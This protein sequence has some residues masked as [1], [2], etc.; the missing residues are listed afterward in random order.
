[1]SPADAPIAP[2]PQPPRDIWVDLA[3]GASRG[4]ALACLPLLLT[5]LPGRLPVN[6]APPRLTIDSG[7]SLAILALGAALG[8][9]AGALRPL[10]RSLVG[11]LLVGCLL[12]DGGLYLIRV[13]RPVR[14]DAPPFHLLGSGLVFG[15]I[16]GLALYLSELHKRSR[17]SS[18]SG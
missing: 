9:V 13:L 7:S 8:A 1:V 15:V 4:V 5:V 6:P 10:S 14:P 12:A 16:L 11:S 17:R 18:L 2:E 3:W